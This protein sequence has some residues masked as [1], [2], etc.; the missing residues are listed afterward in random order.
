MIK[1][2]RPLALVATVVV[3]CS[4][5]ACSSPNSDG[6]GIIPGATGGSPP[7]AT[8]G[9]GGSTPADAAP[10]SMDAQAVGGGASPDGGA[11]MAGDCSPS[12]P[13]SLLCDPLGKMPMTIKETGLFPAAPDLSVHPASMHEYV[14]DP[15]LWSDGMEKQR[16]LL[17][18]PGKKVDTANPKVWVFPIGTTFV[19]TF[20]DDGGAGGKPRAIET[21]LIRREKGK[22]ELFEYAY[23]LYRWSMDGADARLV[24]DDMMGDPNLEAQAMVTV[25]HTDSD[26]KALTVNGGMPFAHTL[27][28]REECGGC[29]DENGMVAQNFIGFDAARLSGKFAPTSTRTQLEDLDAAGVFTARPAPPPP[30][31]D[32]NPTL[33]RIKRFVFGNCVHCHHDGG[34]VFDLSPAVFEKNTINQAVDAQSVVPPKGWLRVVPGKPDISVVYRQVKRVDLPLPTGGGAMN[35]LRPMPPAGVA[36]VAADADALADL[37]SWIMSLPAK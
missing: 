11:M 3:S 9:S 8:G 35:R 25:K 5:L 22:G 1:S 10:G 16:F 13:K 14:P 37:A 32:P 4:V 28:S 34:M 7:G 27:P 31:V 19:K 30:I 33:Q 23:Y 6:R 29:H 20:F 18:P 36:D 12:A 17:L 24:V 15:P 26:G 21:R 2:L